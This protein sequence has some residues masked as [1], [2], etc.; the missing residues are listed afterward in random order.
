MNAYI[1]LCVFT[2]HCYVTV[3]WLSGRTIMACSV[4][5]LSNNVK[6]FIYTEQAGVTQRYHGNSGL[7]EREQWRIYGGRGLCEPP[8]PLAGPP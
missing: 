7:T 8:T 3:D 5:N 2:L 1:L 6:L 4:R